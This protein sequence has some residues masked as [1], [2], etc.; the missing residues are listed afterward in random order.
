MALPSRPSP[1]ST[2]PSFFI[3][4]LVLSATAPLVDPVAWFKKAMLGGD[5]EAF[6]S[7]S[8]S[9]VCDGKLVWVLF[10]FRGFWYLEVGLLQRSVPWFW[11]AMA[12]RCGTPRIYSRV[13]WTSRCLKREWTRPSKPARGLA[14]FP[15]T[16]FSHPLLFARRWL[17]CSPWP[18]TTGK[19]C[20]ILTLSSSSSLSCLAN[21]CLSNNAG[22]MN[23]R[24]SC[25]SSKGW[26]KQSCHCVDGFGVSWQVPVILHN[27]SER[28]EAWSKVFSEDKD[29]GIIPV[30][31]AWQLNE[32]MWV[33]VLVFS[34]HL[35]APISVRNSDNKTCSYI[36]P[37]NYPNLISLL[38]PPLLGWLI[39]QYK[40]LAANYSCLQIVGFWT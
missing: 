3:M 11:S 19:R 39:R 34:S 17:P 24:C 25:R 18:S 31:T 20:G 26:I 37:V 27:E 38:G 22:D 5:W 1:V 6:G 7:L 28:A 21:I 29:D 40:F 15:W 4:P 23:C 9:V 33:P 16:W 30:V 12:S 13:V 35:Q 36:V 2:V 14:S 32:R 10:C 8:L